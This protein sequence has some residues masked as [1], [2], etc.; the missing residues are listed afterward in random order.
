MKRAALITIAILGTLIGALAPASAALGSDHAGRCDKGTIVF[1]RFGDGGIPNLF[2]IS[3]C[4]GATTQLTT[5]GA[6]HA[7]ISSDG[8]RLAYDSIPPGQSTTDVFVANG[9][10]SHARDITN[11]PGSNDIQPD[12]SPDGQQVA[13]SSGTNG[14]RDARIIVQDLSSG[15]TRAVTLTTL[16]QE[17]FD[18][19][20]SPS[21]R[22][23]AFDTF[24]PAAG[25]SYIWVVRSDG[26][27][28]RRITTATDDACQPD[29]GP[30]GLIAYAGG[31]DQAQ[32]HLFIRDPFGV[33]VH[34]LTTDPDGGSSQLPAFSP[35]GRSLTFSRFDAAFNDGD[36]WRLDLLTGVQTDVVPGPTFDYWSAWAAAHN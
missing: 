5:T 1:S 18:P 9:D 32:T 28:L 30:N 23:I 8:R 22:W 21:G 13:Y 20:W 34:Q 7:D 15:Q 3:A 29:W 26:Q 2:S 12:L 19:S 33:F 36:V 17:A 14:L 24:D 16:G 11:A 10:G 25:A 4:G 27:D 31:C 6:H 35:D